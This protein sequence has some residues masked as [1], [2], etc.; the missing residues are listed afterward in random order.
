MG[1]VYFY[2]PQTTFTAYKRIEV[3]CFVN[4]LISIYSLYKV[5][6]RTKIKCNLV[7][8]KL[9]TLKRTSNSLCSFTNVKYRMTNKTL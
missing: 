5:I 3:Y 9:A 8:A 7:F 2:V 6:V 1:A 4:V